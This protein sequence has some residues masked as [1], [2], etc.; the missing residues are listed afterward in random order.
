MGLV[1][2]FTFSALLRVQSAMGEDLGRC[3]FVSILRNEG[4]TFCCVA[5]SGLRSVKRIFLLMLV[6]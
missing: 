1:C 4:R 2:S 5:A 3:P 6:L